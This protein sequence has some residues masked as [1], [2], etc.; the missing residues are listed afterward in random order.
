MDS[1]AGL[2]GGIDIYL[3][4]PTLPDNER[5]YDFQ[6]GSV[7]FFALH[8]DSNEPDGHDANSL[9][10]QWF[11]SAAAASDAMFKIV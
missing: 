10:A 11:E 6:I 4:Y 3:D 1:C 9:Q 7:H 5:Y 2:D 8:S